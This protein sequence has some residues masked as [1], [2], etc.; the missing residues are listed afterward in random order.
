MI[1]PASVSC[2]ATYLM[3]QAHP[4]QIEWV[5]K[6]SPVELKARPKTSRHLIAQTFVKL[7]S[8]GMTVDDAVDFLLKRMAQYVV[9]KNKRK[10]AML[11]LPNWLD[12][13]EYTNDAWEP[14]RTS[15]IGEDM[16]EFERIRAEILAKRGGE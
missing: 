7:E 4:D 13:E 14:R 11:T 2:S 10:Q 5:W 12:E 16:E 6:H 15:T 1:E 9:G 8:Q 3:M